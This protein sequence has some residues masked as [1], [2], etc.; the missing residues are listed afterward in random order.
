MSDT[1]IKNVVKEKYG[2]LAMRAKTGGAACCVQLGGGPGLRRN[3]IQLVQLLPGGA[4]PRG[5]PAR[6]GG[7]R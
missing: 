6:V 3:Y 5:G 1:D 4:N 2:Q 7:L